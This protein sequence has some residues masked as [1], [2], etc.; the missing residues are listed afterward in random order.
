MNRNNVN[1]GRHLENL[2]EEFKKTGSGHCTLHQLGKCPC[3]HPK[4]FC[5]HGDNCTRHKN[6]RGCS[7]I[8]GPNYYLN[9]SKNKLKSKNETD[10]NNLGFEINKTKSSNN[11]IIFFKLYMEKLTKT[12]N[13]HIFLN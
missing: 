13:P 3:F 2:C 8:H 12:N 4:I 5:N 1:M 10:F 7:F 11:D 6:G 9:S